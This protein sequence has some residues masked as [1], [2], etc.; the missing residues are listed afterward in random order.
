M[1]R[2]THF[3][4][5]GFS[6]VETVMALAIMGFAITALLGL[7][8]HGLKMSRQ[9]ADAGAMTRIIDDLSAK[10]YRNTRAELTALIASGGQ[11]QFDEQGILLDQT[12]A[13]TRSV[14]VARVMLNP[15]NIG[16]TGEGVKVSGQETVIGV[17]LQIAS[18][19]LRDFN[20]D[21]ATKKSFHQ[22]PILVG[23]Y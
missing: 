3:G 2:N 1:K 14:Y 19:P 22:V 18:S 5:R 4:N 15:N 23:P 20:F 9:A 13:A 6:L 17:L 12:E 16:L 8:P 7:I 21:T 11:L 10:I